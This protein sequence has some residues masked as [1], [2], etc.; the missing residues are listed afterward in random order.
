[1]IDPILINTAR[2]PSNNMTL[3][4]HNHSSSDLYQLINSCCRWLYCNWTSSIPNLKIQIFCILYLVII[5]NQNP[6]HLLYLCFQLYLLRRFK[7]ETW[8]E[9]PPIKKR[10]A[11][12]TDRVPIFCSLCGQNVSFNGS[13][14]VHE[15]PSSLAVWQ[16]PLTVSAKCKNE[17]PN[18]L[19]VSWWLALGRLVLLLLLLY[20]ATSGYCYC[21]LEWAPW[22]TSWWLQCCLGPRHMPSFLVYKVH[23]ICTYYI[24]GSDKKWPFKKN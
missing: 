21:S 19:S 16:A 2:E 18:D 4:Y 13:L 23:I 22:C 12:W 17:A 9:L 5:K 20:H 11:S 3:S 14:M 24:P 8:P 1:M 10:N 15:A 7:A 6:T